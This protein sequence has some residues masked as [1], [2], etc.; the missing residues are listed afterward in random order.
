M[1]DA[2]GLHRAN[3]EPDEHALGGGIPAGTAGNTSEQADQLQTLKVPGRPRF[4][5]RSD[6]AESINSPSANF[7]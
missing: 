4:P 1:K 5:P 6:C 7:E 3:E 2:S